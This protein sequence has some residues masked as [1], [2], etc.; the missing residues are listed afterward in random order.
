MWEGERPT[1]APDSEPE[2]LGVAETIYQGEG[3]WKKQARGT[4][5][6]VIF[7]HI[8]ANQAKKASRWGWPRGLSQRQ[9][10]GTSSHRL[11]GTTREVWMGGSPAPPRAPAKPF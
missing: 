6:S 3:G 10:L 4:D 7:L 8:K 2:H 5:R 9:N 11:E 1:E